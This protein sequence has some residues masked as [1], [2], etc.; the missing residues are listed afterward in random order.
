VMGE[1][2]LKLL[3]GKKSEDVIFSGSEKRSRSGF[4][5]V[6]MILENDGKIE[7]V[8]MGEIAITRRLYRDGQSEYEV[9]KQAARLSDVV[10][11]LA[12]CGIGQRTYS[13]IGQGMVDAVLVA[14][15]A[16]RKEFFDEAFGLRP[17]QLKRTSAINKIDESR[18]NLL[19]TEQILSEIGPRLNSLERHVKRLAERETIEAELRTLERSY[20]GREWAQVSSGLSSAQNKVNEA[21]TAEAALE[22]EAKALEAELAKMEQATPQGEGFAQLRQAIDAVAAERAALRER[23][24]KLETKKAVAAVRAEKPWSP[25]PLSKIIESVEG[26]RDKHDELHEELEKKDPNLD[27]VKKLAAQLRDT[28]RD[29]ATKLQRPAPEVE[30]EVATD[31]EIDKELKAIAKEAEALV[32]KAR[33]AEAALEAWNKGEEQKRSHIFETQHKLMQKRAEAQT[34]AHRAGE[35]SIDLAR[36]ETRRDAILTEIRL[37]APA[38]E[39]ELDTA[40]KDAGEIAPEAQAR[41]QKLRSQLE[42]I[43]GIDPETIKEHGET[44]ERYDFLSKQV[45]DLRTGIVGLETVVEELDDTIRQRSATAFRKLDKEF[46]A[47]FKKLF[48]GGEASLVEVPPEP[49]VDEEGNILV[50]VKEGEVAGIEIQATPPG[51]R[52]KAIALLSGGERALT[53]IALICAIMA[54]N[55]S[56]FVV[57]DEVDAALDESNSRK[58]AEI[59][60]TLADKTQFVVVTH[61]RAT[62]TQANILYGVTMGDDGVSQLLSVNFDQLKPGHE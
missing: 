28:S 61:N 42:W 22:A 16:E 49:E 24:L 18:K 34:V 10:L 40:A 26:L 1:Q 55:P 19:Q 60:G 57:L 11:L 9:N 12:Q 30:K 31:P 15:P 46:G 20:Y 39:S 59:I 56:P 27:K 32:E 41:L 38:I 62:M 17:F 35:A 53:S 45:E 8:D 33:E 4:A 6:T 47:Y 43:G 51:K 3:R 21:R 29:L 13:V 48:G 54:T 37:H 50:P 58:F 25:L 52:N 36:L 14:T 2:S 5:E 7:G 23:E 44:K